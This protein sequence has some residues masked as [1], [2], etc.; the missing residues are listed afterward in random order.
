MEKTPAVA[1]HVIIST[2]FRFILSD[3]KYPVIK[4]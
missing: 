1:L 4:I 2:T 3:I